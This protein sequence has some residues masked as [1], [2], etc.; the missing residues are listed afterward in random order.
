M[1][2][3][4]F[5]TTTNTRTPGKLADVELRFT[6]DAGPLAGLRLIGFALWQRRNGDGLNLTVPA[7]QYM[8]NGER[9]SY[10]L[11]RPQV[12]TEATIDALRE[13]VTAA[14][15]DQQNPAPYRSAFVPTTYD[16][17]P[18]PP[19]EGTPA[20]R[21]TPQVPALPG[22]T[23]FARPTAP[24]RPTVQPKPGMTPAGDVIRF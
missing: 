10:G 4:H 17:T 7:R 19:V 24:A 15:R 20:A 9:R 13:Q 18:A 8:A 1:Y 21:P 11:V 2:T 22:M 3:I 14:W 23:P 6:G 12:G 16:T 5:D